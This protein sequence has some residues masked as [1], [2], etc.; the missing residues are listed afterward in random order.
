MTP[1]IWDR[2]SVQK[3]PKI[4]RT[5]LCR[6]PLSK[7][8][9]VGVDENQE[10]LLH[11][12]LTHLRQWS[13]HPIAFFDFGMSP[14]A[15][16]WCQQKGELFFL[17]SIELKEVPPHLAKEWEMRYGTSFWRSRSSWFQKPFACLHSPWE[18]AVWLDLDCEVV[19]SIEVLFKAPSLALAKDLAAPTYNSGVIAF[20]RGCPRIQEWAKQTL[21]QGHLFRGDQDLLSS[22][23]SRQAILELPPQFNWP[24]LAPKIAD[25]VIRHHMGE[26]AKERLR[27]GI[28]QISFQTNC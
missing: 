28:Q 15:K 3:N 9:V 17:P 1:K 27:T 12:W 25:V 13:E 5:L 23:L 21:L 19:G 6:H 22:V 26:A 16:K 7:G 4:D 18:H 8:I 24:S 11:F 20:Q 2:K 10:W 14:A